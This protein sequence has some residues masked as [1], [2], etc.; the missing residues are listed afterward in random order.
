M[1][2]RSRLVSRLGKHA[3]PTNHIVCMYVCMY[4]CIYVCIYIYIDID[5]DMVPP[6]KTYVSI[7][8]SCFFLNILGSK[9]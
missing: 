6:P 2:W 8:F 4:V 9:T 7:K 1:G 5:I 3:G